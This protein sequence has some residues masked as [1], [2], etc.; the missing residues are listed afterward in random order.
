MSDDPFAEPDDSE[1]TRIVRPRP[2]G[3]SGGTGGA[4]P[5]RP[6]SPGPAARDAG[7]VP[8]MGT[9][10]LVVSASPVLSAAVRIDTERG[11]GP[12]LER[13]RRAMVDAVQQFERDSLTTGMDPQSL[14]AARYAL[15]A[16]VDDL[17]LSTPEG[18]A[19][20]W[21]QQSMTSI[22]HNEVVGGE[23]F[24][25]ILGQ[26]RNDLGRRLSVVELMYLCMSLGFV[27]RY[28]IQPKDQ[29]GLTLADLRLG[30][31]NDIRNHRGEFER[32]LSP[33]WRGLD[34]GA[35]AL[36]RLIPLWAIG[37]GTLVLAMLM[38]M[39]FSFILAGVSETAFAELYGLPPRG[40][41]A[42]PRQPARAAAVA[43]APVRVSPPGAFALRLRQFLEPEIKAGL[44][45]VLDDAQTTTVRLNGTAMFQSGQAILNKSFAPLIGRIAEALN[46]EAGA[47]QVNGYTDDQP[48]RTARFPSNFELSQARA[49]AV[50]VQ[51]RLKLNDP[52]RPR[53]QGKGQANP[54][55]SNATPTGREKNRRTEIVLVRASDS[56]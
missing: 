56:L 15:C 16:T 20:T 28:R 46:D 14:R 12:D 21:P 52:S 36:A 50:A 55:D 5:A 37:L 4:R 18:R 30:V 38:Y 22:F 19:S 47:V 27:G 25:D 11:R 7:P 6:A 31:Y 44:V 24:F 51:L 9:N 40:T 29:N 17:V 32:D 8:R 3:V 39:A 48:I 2:A 53:V 54:I 13:L 23:R 49:E 35:K 41:V 1:R 42:V 26:M 10:E 43:A 45:S 33:R 34:A